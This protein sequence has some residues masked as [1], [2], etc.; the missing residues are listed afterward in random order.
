MS[1]ASN[2][3]HP[4]PDGQPERRSGWFGPGLLIAASFIGPGMVATATVTGAS[5]GY[6]LVW[7]IVF[8]IVA[9]IILQEMSIRLGLGA[10]LSTGEALRATFASPIPQ[11]LMAVLVI[12]DIG[13]GG[14]AY[15]GGDTTHRHVAG[16]QLRDGSACAGPFPPASPPWCCCFFFPEATSC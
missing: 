5:Y 1:T 12:A 10:R 6:A 7:A 14:A 9:T 11:V 15:A 16:A 4:R 3:S 13:I 2:V 8:S